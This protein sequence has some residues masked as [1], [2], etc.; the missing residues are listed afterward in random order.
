MTGSVIP[1]KVDL[2]YIEKVVKCEPE[3]KPVIS[4]PL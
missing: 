1:R 2:D 4:V 3:R